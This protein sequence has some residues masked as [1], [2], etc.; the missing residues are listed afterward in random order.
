MQ[1][2]TPD[3]TTA[4]DS[5]QG[6]RESLAQ[7][8]LSGSTEPKGPAGLPGRLREGGLLSDRK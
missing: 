2:F 7:L 3:I 6:Q 8:P 4:S 5:A 1:I